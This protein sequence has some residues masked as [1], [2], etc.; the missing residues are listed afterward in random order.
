[1]PKGYGLWQARQFR[2]VRDRPLVALS[3]IEQRFPKPLQPILPCS[4]QF[5]FVLKFKRFWQVAN[6]AIPPFP[7]L[8]RGVRWEIGWEKS[9]V[10]LIAA[11]TTAVIKADIQSA[12]H[13]VAKGSTWTGPY[14]QRIMGAA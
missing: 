9:V 6:H 12:R 2:K 5:R 1:M 11:S 7:T 8:Y 3:R 13:S 4:S 14:A 10:L